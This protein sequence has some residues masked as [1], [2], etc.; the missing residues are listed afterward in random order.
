MILRRNAWKWIGTAALSAGLCGSVLGGCAPDRSVEEDEGPG[1][2]RACQRDSDCKSGRRCID[3]RCYPDRGD[4]QT[5]NDCQNDS[6][7]ACPPELVSERCAC[8]PWGQKPRERS[9]KLCAG[10][11]FPVEEFRSPIVKCQWPPKGMTPPAYKDVLATPVVIDLDGDGETEIVFTAG[12]LG[13]THLIALAGKDCAVKFDKPTPGPG[14]SNLG[15]ADLDGDGKAEI[16]AVASGLTL[17]DHT[18]AVLATRSE[19]GAGLL[20]VRDYAIAFANLDGEG[21]P[22]V[23]VGAAAFRYLNNPKPQLQPLWNKNLIEEGAWGTIPVVADLD[24]DGRAEVITGHNVFDGMTGIDKTPAVMKSLGGGYAAVAD[25]NADGKPDI[26]LVSSRMDDQTVSIVDYQG[27]RLL[28][29]PQAAKNGWGGAPTIAD[30]D[31]D[32]RPEIGTAGASYYYVYSP[33]CAQ[34]PLPGKCKGVDEGVLWQ[35]AT[36]DLSSGSTGSSV[37]DFNGDGLAE[38][39]YR[40]ECWLRVFSG[41]DGQKLFAAPVTSGTVLDEPVIADVDGDGHAEI[42]VASDA[43][44]NDA[45]RKGRWSTEL[46]TP[47]SGATYG[48][49]VLEDP[50]DRWSMARPL[51]NQHSYHITNINDDRTIPLREPE[52]WKVHN[53]YRQNLPSSQPGAEPRPDST[54]GI[55]FPPDVGDCV[56]LFRLSGLVCNRGAAP[57]SAGLPATFYLGDPQQVGARVLCTTKTDKAIAAGD[58]L[59][60]SCEWNNPSPPPYD[61]WL[62]VN[63]DGKGSHPVAECKSGNNLAHKQLSAC[64]SVPK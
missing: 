40:D 17:F 15:A 52:S 49:R 62:R 22:E 21:N 6:A 35:S 64:P 32:G 4:C 14:C 3:R 36:Q 60:I 33:D 34:S 10:A 57:L 24:G 5:D 19:I 63:D 38:V 47:H 9:D 20:C 50:Q 7:C 26:A 18:G 37:F 41:R 59:G 58:C 1:P 25:F 30:F 12:Y 46:G 51:W 54:G 31:G 48:V 53:T 42:V 11:G 44:Q 61:L 56:T 27:K 8:I 39:V 23:I 2:G 45:C 55:E 29:P 16:V 28:L 43:A 13:S